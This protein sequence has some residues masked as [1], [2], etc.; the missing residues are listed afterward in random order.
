MPARRYARR[1]NSHERATEIANGA[2]C[3]VPTGPGLRSK[4]LRSGVGQ[5]RATHCP[6]VRVA[7]LLVD[8]QRPAWMRLGRA[9]GSL[10]SRHARQGG[11]SRIRCR[12]AIV[13]TNSSE[14]REAE[15]V[16]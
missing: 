4:G 8:F 2:G 5:L 12:I 11:T 3:A 13:D 14:A 16:P 15:P 6:R 7:S 1:L 9:K 10:P